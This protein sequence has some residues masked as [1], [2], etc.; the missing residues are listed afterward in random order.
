MKVAIPGPYY[1]VYV[2]ISVQGRYKPQKYSKAWVF[3]KKEGHV[4]G[5][6]RGLDR[7]YI[8]RN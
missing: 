4:M 2:F 8:D 6:G 7:T 5:P 1:T 3:P